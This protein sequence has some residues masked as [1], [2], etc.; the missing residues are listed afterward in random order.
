M[1][2]KKVVQERWNQNVAYKESLSFLSE[3]NIK[4]HWTPE[5]SSNTKDAIWQYLQ[6]LYMLGT[7]ITAF[8]A[9][10]LNMIESVASNM[11]QQISEG[12]GSS[13]GQLDEAALMNSVQ[14]LLGNIGNMGNLLGNGKQ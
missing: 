6:T 12:G 14:G 4:K 8:P 13:G 3:L 5:L 9:D 11:A 10:T 2:Y 1:F 7:T